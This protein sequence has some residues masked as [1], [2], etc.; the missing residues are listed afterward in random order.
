MAEPA[1]G[2]EK[3]VLAVVSDIPESPPLALPKYRKLRTRGAY[4]PT[5]RYTS[6][7]KYCAL[8]GGSMN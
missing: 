6:H 1:G 8:H 5:H 4:L 7:Q 2:Q 3:S